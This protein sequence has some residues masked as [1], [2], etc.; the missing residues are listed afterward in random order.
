[1]KKCKNICFPGFKSIF[2]AGATGLPDSFE[3]LQWPQSVSPAPLNIFNGL[4]P[5]RRLLWIP[6]MA[7]IRFAGSV[8]YLQWPQSG[9]LA[10]LNTFN[11]LNPVRRLCWIPSMAS[12]RFAG[13]VEYLQ[14]HQSGWWMI[15]WISN[16]SP[17]KY[18]LNFK[19]GT[20]G[21]TKYFWMTHF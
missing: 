4:N 12:I 21:D 6:S 16:L 17:G 13:S 3:Y 18:R 2:P 8:E 10:L 14:W 9:P 19:C 1:M 11:G 7:S 5:V 15:I 20:T